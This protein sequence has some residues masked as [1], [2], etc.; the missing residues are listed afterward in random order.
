MLGEGQNLSNAPLLPKRNCAKPHELDQVL[1]GA[2]QSNPLV[3]AG[4]HCA[5]T[6]GLELNL[7]NIADPRLAHDCLSPHDNFTWVNDRDV[8]EH[9]WLMS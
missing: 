3:S 1:A 8:T 2:S 7:K 6:I 5:H 4:K 9:G